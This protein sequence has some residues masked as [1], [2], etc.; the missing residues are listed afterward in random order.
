MNDSKV[1]L[2]LFCDIFACKFN[3][4]MTNLKIAIHVAI[5]KLSNDI[6]MAAINLI[7]EYS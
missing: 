2:Q 3:P 7:G 4:W 1:L 6:S 5:I